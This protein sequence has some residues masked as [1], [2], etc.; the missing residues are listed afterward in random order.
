MVTSEQRS[1]LLP[2]VP[3]AKEAGMPE[4]VMHFW[5]GFAAP[6][7]TPRPVI[8]KLNKEIVAALRSD[9]GRKRLA[10][11]GLEPVANTPTEAAKLVEAE[12]RRWGDLVKSAGIKAE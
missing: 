7:G 2:D 10:D 3:S 1:A 11:Q 12:M 4:M 6:A 9:A 8:D 5:V